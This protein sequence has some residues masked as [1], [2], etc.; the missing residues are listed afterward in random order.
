MITFVILVILM[1]WSSAHLWSLEDL[2]NGL[3]YPRPSGSEGNLMA[4]QFI[5]TFFQNLPA[6]QTE[7]DDFDQD[8]VIGPV[9]FSNIIA[10]AR[11]Q[12]TQY[13]LLG[14]SLM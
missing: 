11:P 3:L 6:W 14:L 4:R 13:M 2:T 5:L 8:T 9:T 1:Q 10:R 7:T 12:C